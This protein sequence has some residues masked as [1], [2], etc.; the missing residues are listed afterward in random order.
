MAS[1]TNGRKKPSRLQ[2]VTARIITAVKS[3][4]FIKEKYYTGLTP[5]AQL[6]FRS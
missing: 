3:S 1:Q 4:E 5:Y 6:F 2:G